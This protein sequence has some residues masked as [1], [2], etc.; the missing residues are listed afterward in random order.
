[1]SISN[2]AKT[3]FGN[4]CVDISCKYKE[5]TKKHHPDMSGDKLMF[6]AIIRAK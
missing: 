6:R 2:F 5:L 4:D 1:M 3:H